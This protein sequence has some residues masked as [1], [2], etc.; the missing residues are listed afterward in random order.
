MAIG[1]I[2]LVTLKSEA[3]N[4]SDAGVFEKC[5]H[6]GSPILCLNDFH[7]LFSINLIAISRF[8]PLFLLQYNPHVLLIIAFLAGQENSCKYITKAYKKTILLEL[9]AKSINS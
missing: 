8:L 5:H 6:H 2:G 1:T 4:F 9:S 3:D 7:A